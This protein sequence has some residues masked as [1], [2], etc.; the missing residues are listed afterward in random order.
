MKK[1]VPIELRKFNNPYK[2]IIEHCMENNDALIDYKSEDLIF[3]GVHYKK[4]MVLC[5]EENEFDNY[6]FCEI[7][8]I[9]V[10]LDGTEIYFVGC[11]FEVAFNEDFGE[12]EMVEFKGCEARSQWHSVFFQST[13]LSSDPILKNFVENT[14]VFLPKYAMFESN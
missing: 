10:R 9:L 3:M 13:L 7:N 14:P 2:L 1:C 5:V 6:V 11:T 4:G 12:S 8:H